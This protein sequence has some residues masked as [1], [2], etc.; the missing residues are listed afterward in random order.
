VSSDTAGTLRWPP[1]AGLDVFPSITE[2]NR[3]RV[4]FNLDVKWEIVNDL[5]FLINY[6]QNWDN[7]SDT[8]SDYG[9]V[10]SVGYSL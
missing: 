10:S 7:A 4:N 9:I 1:D 8:G 2:T 6:F 3:T 5:D